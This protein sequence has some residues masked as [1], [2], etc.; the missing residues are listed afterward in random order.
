MERRP[1]PELMLDVEQARAYAQADFEA[2]HRRCIELLRER[3]GDLPAHGRAADL[4]CGP[5]DVTLRLARVLPAWRIDAFDGSPAMLAWAHEA[6]QRVGVHT[7]TFIE[8]LLPDHQPP[9][10]AYDLLLSN[11]LLHHLADPS[12]LWSLLPRWGRRG[13]GVFVMDLLRPDDEAAADAL[14]VQYAAG[15]PDV[16][17]QDFAN[18]LRAAYRPSEVQRQLAAAGLEQLAVEVVSD[19][20]LLVWGQL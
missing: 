7:V 5:G 14:V 2:P 10:A 15:E 18:S 13:A 16:L 11:S 1:E 8:A 19:R 20:H 12:A 3:F 6:A 17:R 4:G 9:H